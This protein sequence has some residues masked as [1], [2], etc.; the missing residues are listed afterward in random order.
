MKKCKVLSCKFCCQIAG[1]WVVSS[2]GLV[3]TLSFD[4]TINSDTTAAVD[5]KCWMEP[6]GQ[7]L[8]GTLH[9]FKEAVTGAGFCSVWA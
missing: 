4:K 7:P 9:H 2:L 1:G 6:A 8:T 5:R 3:P